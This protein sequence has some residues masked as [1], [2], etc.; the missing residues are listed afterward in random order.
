MQANKLDVKALALGGGVLWAA[1]IILAGWGSIFG[2]G[3]NFVNAFSNLYIGYGSS[4]AGGLI[5]G[6]WGFLDGA[7]AGL[8]IALVYNWVTAWKKPK[9]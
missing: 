4:W 6:L 7:I 5:G 3:T 1:Y 9:R 8:V 2:W